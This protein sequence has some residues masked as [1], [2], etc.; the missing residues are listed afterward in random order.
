MSQPW[1]DPNTFAWVPGT[2]FGSLIGCLGAVAGM[3][4]PSG[5]AKGYVLGAWYTFIAVGILLL[6]ISLFALITGQPYGIWYGFGLPGLLGVILL[7]SLLP[8]I[9]KR[10]SEAEQRKMQSEDLF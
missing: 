5:K 8:V 3:L 2:V 4:A 10:Y 6:F 7:P 1:F 9:K